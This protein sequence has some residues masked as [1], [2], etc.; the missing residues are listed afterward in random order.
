M[1]VTAYSG[2]AGTGK[3]HCLMEQVKGEVRTRPLEA[4]ERVLALTFMHGSRRRLDSRLREIAEIKGRH[5]AIT[6]DSLAW[7]LCKRWR[8]LAA[9]LSVQIPSEA[10]FDATCALAAVLLSRPDVASWVRSSYPIVIVDEAQDLT[11]PRSEMVR[12]L[13]ASCHVLLAFD[14]FQ[15]LNPTMSSMPVESWLFAS[16]EPKILEECHR[17]DDAELLA[18]ARALRKGGAPKKEGRRFKVVE[19]PSKHLAAAYL[20]NFIAWRRGGNVAVLTPSRKGVFVDAIVEL[21]RTRKLG[22]QRNGP[23]LIEW[24]VP[25]QAEA[26]RLSALTTLPGQ[27]SPSEALELLAPNSQEPAVRTVVDWVRG[28]AALGIDVLTGDQIRSRIN[29]TITESRHFGTQTTRK[30][31]AMTIQQAKNRE[32]DHVAVVWPY[33]VPKNDDQRRRLLYNAI[34]RARRSCLVMVQS[35]KLLEEAPFSG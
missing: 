23:Y 27:C 7:R 32:F 15:C 17:T 18:A 10:D 29:R 9:S 8:T 24:E 28:R 25:A 33:T 13:A 34:T 4:N 26:D 35:T 6:L 22:K 19:T 11:E 2:P 12:H 5:R 3:T 1:T 21:V 31:G 30:Y 16:C 14:E 20:A